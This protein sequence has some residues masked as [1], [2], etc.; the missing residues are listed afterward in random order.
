MGT[1]MTQKELLPAQSFELRPLYE[2]DRADFCEALYQSF[3]VWYARHGWQGDYFRGDPSVCEI[4]YDLYNDLSPGCSV[5]AVDSSTGKLMG[6]CFYHPREHHVSLGIMSVHPDYWSRGVGKALVNHIIDYTES[7]GFDSLRLVS[8][9]MNVD[10]FSLYNTSGFV[11]RCTYND[12]ILSVPEEGLNAS[13][14]RD[15]QV[16]PATL[17]DIPAMAALEME[18]SGICREKDYRYCIEN[19]RGIL[20]T[21]VIEAETGELNGFL[22]SIKHPALN[23]IGPGVARSEE[24]GVALLL[25][26][27]DIFRGETPLFLIPMQKRLLVES[28]Y[29]WGARNVELHLCEVRG[30]Y[31][32]PR[33]VHFPSFLPETG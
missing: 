5:C 3:N 8:S 20:H 17:E 12:M 10:S 33:G 27:L 18:I 2:E 25:A 14:D 13:S 32:E 21:S 6:S 19:K 31:Q 1:T 22:F 4:F 28:A 11:P 29:R 24:D 23:M 9:A 26:E 7:N 16:R 30:A 15:G